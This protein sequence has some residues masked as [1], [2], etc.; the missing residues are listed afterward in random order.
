MAGQVAPKAMIDNRR[1][2]R[3]EAAFLAVAIAFALA[4]R[5]LAVMLRGTYLDFDE[6][7]YIALGR[8]LVTGHGYVLNGLPNVTFPFGVPLIAG[9]TWYVTHSARCALNAP[10]ALFGALTVIPVYLI[11]RHV[12]NRLA[13]ATAVILYAGF[14]PFLFL[15]PYCAY[16]ER[17]YSGSEAMFLFFVLMASYLFLRA[18]AEPT[19]TF[20]LIGGFFSGIAFQVRQDALGYFLALLAVTYA[21]IAIARRKIVP[22]EYLRFAAGALAVFAFIV[23]PY[24][25]WVKH[26]TGRCYQGPRFSKTFEM[27]RSLTRVIRGDDWGPALKDYFQPNA[28]NTQIETSYY[29]V[30]PYHR[31][32]IE[33]GAEDIPLKTLIGALNFYNPRAAWTVLWRTLIPIGL[34]VFVL[35]GFISA[36]A[37]K[38]WMFLAVI[39]ALV[40]P[41]VWVTL[42]LYV[43]GRFYLVPAVA[44]LLIGARGLDLTVRALLP[45][46]LGERATVS[47][48]AA[49]LAY[50][51]VPTAF[52]VILA[53]DTIGSARELRADRRDFERKLEAKLDHLTPHLTLLIPAG[54]RVVTWSP[55]PSVRADFTWLAMPEAPPEAV[56]DYCHKRSADFLL[57]RDGDGH[58][59]HYSTDDIVKLIGGERL[60]FN[61]NFSGEYFLLFDLRDT[62]AI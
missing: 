49:A 34:W 37:E 59:Q 38:R 20:G 2:A 51:I 43:L 35:I 17:L 56:V 23:A 19:F 26:V 6:S 9:A 45:I 36:V 15:V 3:R 21:A 11:I 30:S 14:P 1:E 28:D 27:R 8:S 50:L 31:A 54:S 48:R 40:I 33:A 62:P 42:T 39:A 29:G 52:A 18:A 24:F 55:A 58:F 46:V 61:R 41:S 32:R 4:L 57:L 12:W 44:M 5:V 10:T 47:A 13:A 16:A 22:G 53:A 7:M 25:L 60:L